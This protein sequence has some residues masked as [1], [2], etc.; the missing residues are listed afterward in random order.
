MKPCPTMQ[1]VIEALAAK[2]RL[3]L[4]QFRANI[5]LD[6]PGYDRLCIEHIGGRLISV[7]HYYEHNGDLV[8]DP[9]IVFFADAEWGW[10]PIEITQSVRAWL[11]YA[12]AHANGKGVVPLR[13][14]ADDLVAFAE[15]WARNIR[16]QGWLEA[17]TRHV[18]PHERDGEQV[19]AEAQPLETSFVNLE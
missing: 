5:R 1:A 12:T 19:W 15:Q 3:D 7:A 17:A 11:R 13:A 10:I 4:T 18:Y 8:P 14:S 2:H 9:E 16:D 6:L